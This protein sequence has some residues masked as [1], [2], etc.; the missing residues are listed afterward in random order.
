MIEQ[1][2]PLAPNWPGKLAGP[3]ARSCNCARRPPS[4]ALADPSAPFKTRAEAR[5]IA[6]GLVRAG[7]APLSWS[8][9][10][11]VLGADK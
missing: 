9:S 3:A 7:R 5:L 8:G 6:A 4:T 11:A 10:L 2:L 1:M